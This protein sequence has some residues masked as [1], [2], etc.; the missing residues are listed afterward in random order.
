MLRGEAAGGQMD[1]KIKQIDAQ[2]VCH[3][4]AKALVALYAL[5][6]HSHIFPRRSLMV[7][8]FP[9]KGGVLRCI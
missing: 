5:I 2:P 4:P 9:D 8:F 6:R 3:T 7:H 1:V